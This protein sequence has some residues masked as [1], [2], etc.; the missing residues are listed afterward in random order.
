MSPHLLTWSIGQLVIGA[1]TKLRGI[2][3]WA[4]ERDAESGCEIMA[5][6]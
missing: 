4:R 1:E 5:F 2:W 3:G 6:R